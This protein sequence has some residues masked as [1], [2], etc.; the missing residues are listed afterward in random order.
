MT[1]VQL[2]K[3]MILTGCCFF[4]RI[5]RK[6]INICC[7]KPMSQCISTFCELGRGEKRTIEKENSHN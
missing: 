4:N 1:I 2:Q 5:V 3:G 6:Q 7:S